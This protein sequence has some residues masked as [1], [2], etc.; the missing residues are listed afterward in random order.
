MF[1]QTLLLALTQRGLGSCVELSV[2]GNP[3]ILRAQLAISEE[4]SIL[5]GVAI[6]Y[7]DPDF[8]ANQLH[9]ERE[10]IRENIVFVEK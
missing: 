4:L 2:T 10:P 1:L 3:G 7:S 8:A 9:I 6:G 5:C